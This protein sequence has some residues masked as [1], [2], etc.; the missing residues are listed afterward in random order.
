MR[1]AG[2]NE[3]SP[4]RSLSY[5]AAMLAAML[6]LQPGRWPSLSPLMLLAVFANVA[7]SAVLGD[8]LYIYSINKIGA[9]LAVSVNCAY[10]LVTTVVSI[11]VL[12]EKITT[13]IWVGTICIIIGLLLV[14]QGISRKKR[15]ADPDRKKELAAKTIAVGIA[16]AAGSAICSG[17]NNPFIKVIMREGGWNPVETYFLRSVAYFVIVWVV[18]LIEWRKFP[19]IV[20]PLRKVRLKS[21]LALLGGGFVALALGGVLFGICVNVLPVSIVT[22]ITASS[23]LITVIIARLFYKERL[24]GVQNIGVV[25]VILG[26]IAVSL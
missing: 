6:I 13:L 22:P 18:R 20:M 12:G 23:P 1:R 19:H 2:P 4:I 14:T 3:V 8:Q 15:E 7:T 16:L 25:F 11:L 9:S 24:T 5:F 17:V 21:W 26:S 10:P